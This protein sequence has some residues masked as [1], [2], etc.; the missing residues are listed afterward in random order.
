MRMAIE[1][2]ECEFIPVTYQRNFLHGK[3]LEM[4]IETFL[5]KYR[6]HRSDI[7]QYRWKVQVYKYRNYDLSVT[8]WE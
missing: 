5:K 2:S 1:S 8:K 7:R 4:S 3:K 6:F